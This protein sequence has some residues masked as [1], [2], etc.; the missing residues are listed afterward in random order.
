MERQCEEIFPKG[1]TIIILCWHEYSANRFSDICQ[2]HCTDSPIMRLCK[3][4]ASLLSCVCVCA[5]VCAI[6][7]PYLSVIIP[8]SNAHKLWH[9]TH[10]HMHT[11][12]QRAPAGFPSPSSPI[13]SS[14]TQTDGS[15]HTS[16][17]P[18]THPRCYI[19]A[20]LRLTNQITIVT[21]H[22]L[23]DDRGQ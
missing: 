19:R 8:D 22:T 12:A 10:R 3:S 15:V 21:G 20:T 6:T 9:A 4:S 18:Q 1:K 11:H 13:F 7:H 14:S 17:Q 5:C 16:P 2:L 23:R